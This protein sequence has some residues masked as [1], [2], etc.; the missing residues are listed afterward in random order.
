[1]GRWY[2][3]LVHDRW[4]NYDVPEF[5]LIEQDTSQLCTLCF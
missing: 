2:A 4:P 1:M 3:R 5:F